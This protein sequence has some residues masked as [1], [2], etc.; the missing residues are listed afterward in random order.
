LGSL[1]VIEG[2][3]GSGKSTQTDILI[4]NFK[5]AGIDIKKIKLPDYENKS[6]TLVK[7]YLAGDFGDDPCDVNAY[8]ASSFYAVD[9]F[10]SYSKW[11]NSYKEGTVIIADRYTTSNAYHQMVKLPQKEWDEYLCWLEDFEYKKIGIPKPELVIYLDMPVDISQELMTGRYDG[12]EVKKD[13]HESNISY[14]QSCRQAALYAA[15]M[16]GWKVI[17]CAKDGKPL[18]IDEI[19]KAIWEYAKTEVLK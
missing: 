10:A 12:N 17:K 13:V 3:D 14:L 16:L 6:S 5:N 4:S 19:S 7:M 18:S 8:A 15:K 2:L 1:V 11:K 9:R